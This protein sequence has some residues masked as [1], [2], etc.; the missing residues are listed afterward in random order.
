MWGAHALELLLFLAFVGFATW[1]DLFVLHRDDHEIGLPEA[2]WT[3]AAWIA[4]A[5]AF[6]GYIWIRYGPELWMQYLTGY[7]LEKALSIDNLFVI[8]VLF[9]LLGVRGG[10]QHRAL[11][12]GVLGAVVMRGF[13]IVVGV[14]LVHRFDW[15]LP[16]F[17]LFLL[18]SAGRMLGG[19]AR[20][21]P[22]E[23]SPLYRWA[24][25]RLPIHRGFDGHRLIT[26][27]EGRW[28]LTTLGLAILLVEGTD[29]LFAVDSLPAVMG[30]S[31]D[32]FVVLTSNLFA[33]LG[34]RALYFLLAGSLTRFRYLDVGLGLVLAFIGVK[35]VAAPF[36]LHMP[37]AASLAVVLA[38]VAVAILA[39]LRTPERRAGS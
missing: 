16:L 1:L 27:Q 39:S 18:W 32:P 26:R 6:S 4:L 11:A 19:G 35:M 12:W 3:S 7:V 33:V 20:R 8:A 38:T 36:G 37:V 17:G 21:R 30:V 14:E 23:R 10:L 2:A 25:G 15:L 28:A 34:L 31:T 13:L 22:L 24:T 9:G 29:L 5:L